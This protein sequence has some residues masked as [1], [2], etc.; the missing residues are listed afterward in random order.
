MSRREKIVQYI[1][2]AVDPE[3][4]AEADVL[5]QVLDSV[6]LLQLI[7][8][9]DQELGVSL[10]LSDLTLDAFASVDAVLDTLNAHRPEA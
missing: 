10:E 2:S 4:D 9:I 6:S 1:R 3:F 8:Y 5:T 7:V